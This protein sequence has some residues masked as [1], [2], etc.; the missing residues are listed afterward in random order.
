METVG[1]KR[2]VLFVFEVGRRYEVVDHSLEMTEAKAQPGLK[3]GGG[4][5]QTSEVNKT[6]LVLFIWFENQGIMY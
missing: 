4:Q 5:K 6:F 1:Y 3:I 2:L